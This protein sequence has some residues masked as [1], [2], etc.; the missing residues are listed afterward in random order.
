M[1]GTKQIRSAR[2]EV[3]PQEVA[4]KLNTIPWYNLF[5]S[6]PDRPL[7]PSSQR[8]H[9]KTA[10]LVLRP[11]DLSDLEAFHSLRTQ[12]EVMAKTFRPRVDRDMD[13]TRTLLQSLQPPNDGNSWRFGVFLASTGELIGDGGVY[14]FDDL[15]RTGW[16]ELEFML[17]KEHWGQGYGKELIPALM[18]AWFNLPRSGV[19]KHTLHPNAIGELEP[20]DE[21]PDNLAIIFDA[22]IDA[23]RKIVDGL[24]DPKPD[25]IADWE[26]IDWR[27][28]KEFMEITL[29]GWLVAN[30]H[31][32]DP[33][34]TETGYLSDRTD[35]EDNEKE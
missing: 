32:L 4:A 10:R 8:A 5:T 28:G 35:V 20:G 3:L 33:Y 1:T 16:P 21:L 24:T 34:R 22:S 12:P 9:I 2:G 18:E 15:W 19:R 14:N 11:L 6:L 30:P 23:A 31:G 26:Q 7:P 29:A 25:Y 13:E 27:E 17:R